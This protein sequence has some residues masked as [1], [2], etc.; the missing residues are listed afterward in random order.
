MNKIIPLL[1]IFF[2]Y[3][4]QA[5]LWVEDFSGEANGATSGTAGGT[6]GGTWS[7][8]TAPSSGTFSRQ[9]FLNT[10]FQINNTTNE[11][12]WATNSINISSVG[13]A[14]INIGVLVGGFGFTA[15]DY[16][17]F[18]YR[19]D[20]GPEVLFADI[21]GSLLSITTEASAIV[22][23]NTLQIIARGVD[24]S[25]FGLI[26]FDDVTI[27][28]APIL[29]SRKSGSWTDVTG[30]FGGSG[31]WSTDPSGTPACGCLPLNDIVAIIQNGHTVTLPNNLTDVEPV[32]A[33]PAPGAVEVR[34]GGVLQ[35]NTNGVTLGIQAGYLRVTNGGIINSSSGAITGER[36]TFQADVGGARFQVDTGGSASIEDLELSA[37]ATNVHY[38]EGGGSLTIT[39]DILINADNAT[40]ENNMTSTVAIT[41]RIEFA[42][43]TI[44]SEFINDG[45]LTAAT[46]FFDD[47]NNS[48]TNNSTISGSITV[49]SNT[50]DGNSFNNSAAATFTLGTI[51]LNNGNFTINNSGTINQSGNFSNIDNGSNGNFNNLATGTWNWSLTPNTT[52]DIDMSTVLD[53]AASGNTFNYNA[54]GDQRIIPVQYSN[55]TLS[56]SGA[57]DSN[58]ASISLNGNWLVSGSA[59]FTEGTGTVTF[60]GA[61]AQLITSTGT[62]TFNNLTI[63][64]SF[65]TSPQLTLNNP[66]SVTGTFTMTD[67]NINL[68]TNTFTIG[69]SAGS[70]G[71]LSH[72]G[73][74][75]NG[76]MYG[77]TLRR[78]MAAS[79]PTTIGGGDQNEGFF[80]LGSTADFRPFFVGKNNNAGTGG[81]ISVTHNNSTTTSTVSIADTGPVA[82]I[83]RRHDSNWAVTT[84]GITGGT[85]ALQSGG[86]TFGT[87]QEL[88]DLRMSISAGV[89]GT[90]SAAIGSIA[91]PRVNRT[92]L[93]FGQLTNNFHLAST[94]ATNSPLPVV[95]LFFKGES[96]D[97]GVSL[98]W[99]TASE[100][101]NDFFSIERSSQGESFYEVARVKG[102]GTTNLP[103]KYLFNDFNP[104]IG[105]AYYRLKQVDFDGSSTYSNVISVE[106]QEPEIPLLKVFPNPFDGQQIN[107]ELINTKP[108]EEVSLVLINEAGVVVQEIILKP[109]DNGRKVVTSLEF[110]TPLSKGIYILKV[111]E[112][113]FLTEKL[114]VK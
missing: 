30:G 37:A 97:A 73:A 32:V 50:D 110:K 108:S 112:N 8:T 59:S 56:N 25:F 20:G 9:N 95:L 27:T 105:R 46:L 35:F 72:G 19:L 69:T 11:G 104:V 61:V 66:V 47:D 90:H 1:F 62:E 70:P 92:S 18:Y 22:S 77:G 65:A 23:G 63:N 6:L 14:I 2:S 80:P 31:T 24:N 52:F 13:Y 33:N 15:S 7:V 88:P 107:I 82:T 75:A 106:Y 98:I 87:I 55:L 91:D 51:N 79:N 103:N 41:D 76:W 102:N 113:S 101:N 83:T 26:I 17:R 29:Y 16:L 21:S 64:N 40:L 96:F 28:A 12:V 94:D 74:S 54:A 71:T 4:A 5:Q 99:E 44:D 68:N 58:N 86:T 34:N 48:I 109:Q 38:L 49:N 93:T 60:N 42:A 36:I 10:G 53:C 39:D 3:A 89:V 114:I 45:P 67:G 111:G 100:L 85:W 81:S 84:S 43:G 78:F 57:K